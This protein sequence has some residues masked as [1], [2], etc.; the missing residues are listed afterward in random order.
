MTQ[1][2]E[3]A[4]EASTSR[5]VLLAKARPSHVAAADVTGLG[6]ETK[7]APKR[8]EKKQPATFVSI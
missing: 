1:F 4:R 7:P 5:S 2:S 3:V 8:A 6:Q